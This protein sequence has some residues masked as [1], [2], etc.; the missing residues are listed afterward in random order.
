MECSAGPGHCDT[1]SSCTVRAP[2]QRINRAVRGALEGM[3]LAELAG[4]RGA[5]LGIDD[6]APGREA[7]S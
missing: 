3:T 5:L 6:A 1:E 2:W 7:R 4:L